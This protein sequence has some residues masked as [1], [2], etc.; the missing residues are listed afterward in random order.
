MATKKLTDDLILSKMA[1]EHG[2]LPPEDIG[3]DEKFQ[4]IKDHFEFSISADW[5]NPDFMF[6]SETTADGY[7]VWIATDNDRNPSVNEDIYYYD[8][9]WLEKMANCMYDGCSIYYQDA[10]CDD[11]AFQDVVDEVYEEYWGDIKKDVENE[12][13]EQGYERKESE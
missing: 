3:F 9:D 2:C 4:A 10:D 7:E 8:S 5:N 11:Y 6:Y 12:L 13:I 1:E